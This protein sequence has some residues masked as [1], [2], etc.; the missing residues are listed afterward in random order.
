MAPMVPFITEHVWQVLIRVA[1]PNQKESIH[2]EDF[3]NS[4]LSK[5][6]SKHNHRL[7]FDK[8]LY[9]CHL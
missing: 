6:D 9:K 1:E 2:L 3:P 7:I 5:I 4:D 8:N